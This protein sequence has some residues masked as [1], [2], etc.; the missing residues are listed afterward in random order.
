MAAETS[1]QVEVIQVRGRRVIALTW[2]LLRRHKFIVSSLAG[3]DP[4]GILFNLSSHGSC[5]G[6]RHEVPD[7]PCV[8]PTLRTFAIKRPTRH[9]LLRLRFSFYE[10]LFLIFPS[11]HLV[12]RRIGAHSVVGSGILACLSHPPQSG[13]FTLLYPRFSGPPLDKV[14]ADGENDPISAERGQDF[15]TLCQFGQ[16][17]R[18]PGATGYNPCQL[19]SL[20]FIGVLHRNT[21]A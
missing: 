9:L 4:P 10:S 12:R 17:A 6:A 13:I 21:G 8:V 19:L 7:L 11:L 18:A 5:I 3:N 1:T 15:P 14:A 20:L 16:P 2:I